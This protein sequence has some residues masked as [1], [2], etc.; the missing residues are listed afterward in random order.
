MPR[1]LPTLLCRWLPISHVLLL[2]LCC[3]GPCGR[4]QAGCGGLLVWNVCFRGAGPQVRNLVLLAIPFVQRQ[5]DALAFWFGVSAWHGGAC[6]LGSGGRARRGGRTGLSGRGGRPLWLQP[7]AVRS[8]CCLRQTRP[9]GP[10]SSFRI[11][12]G[13]ENSRFAGQELAHMLKLIVIFSVSGGGG[14]R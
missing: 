9:L 14:G 10:W 8:V 12:L 1:G 5:L 3:G 13:R 11:P 2:G 7:Q 4:G 6:G